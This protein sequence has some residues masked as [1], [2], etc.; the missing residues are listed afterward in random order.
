MIVVRHQTVG[1]TNPLHPA[2]DL[3]QDIDKGLSVTMVQVNIRPSIATGGDMVQGTWKF[4]AQQSNVVMQDLTP[5]FVLSGGS[6]GH[7]S[8]NPLQHGKQWSEFILGDVPDDII[9]DLVV[10]MHDA[11]AYPPHLWPG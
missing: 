11:V 7:F 5:S 2:A 8:H 6:F 4:S 1:I 9:V 3:H 10:G